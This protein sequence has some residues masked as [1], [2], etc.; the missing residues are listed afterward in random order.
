MKSFNLQLIELDEESFNELI[1]YVVAF[2]H[3]ASGLL[4]SHNAALKDLGSLE[5]SE[6]EDVY[7]AITS[8]DLHQIDMTIW[9]PVVGYLMK[10][11]IENVPL[12]RNAFFVV[13]NLHRR[14]SL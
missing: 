13:P 11:T 6:E 7:F 9:I 1:E 2:A 14:R 12:L 4:L 5:V 8:R 3:Q 10:V